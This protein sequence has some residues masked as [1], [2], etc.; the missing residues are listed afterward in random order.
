MFR[1]PSLLLC[2]SA[3]C[4]SS[5]APA[6]VL[7]PPSA[8][9]S[10][11]ETA[12]VIEAGSLTEG[13]NQARLAKL[14]GILA[15]LAG[16]S[17]ARGIIQGFRADLLLGLSRADEARL[18]ADESVR[19]LPGYS[20]PLFLA[21]QV[22]AYGDQ[23]E[24]AADY[25]IRASRIDPFLLQ[26]LDSYEVA[27][28][29]RRLQMKGEVERA[30]AFG[31]RLLDVSWKGDDLSTRS[32]MV[33]TLLE[34]R[35]ERGELARARGL[36]P[37][38]VDPAD[39]YRLLAVKRYRPIW[40]ELEAWAGSR[41]EKQW[42]VYLPELRE[43]WEASR[44]LGAGRSYLRG[45]AMANHNRA[46]VAE[47]LPVLSGPLNKDESA[48][49]LLMA[50]TVARALAELGRWDEID[51]MYSR[52][53]GIWPLGSDVM[54]LNL[55]GN[56]ARYLL[57]AGKAEQALPLIDA[58]IAEA[59]KRRAEVGMDAMAVM[60]QARACILHSLGRGDEGAKS[61]ALGRL[62]SPS[63]LSGV[64]SM[65]SCLERPEEARQAVLAAFASPQAEEEAVL[66]M[67][68]G[69]EQPVGSAFGQRLSAA[70]Q[71]LQADPVLLAAT[72]KHGRIL[73]F[74]AGSAA[75]DEVVRSAP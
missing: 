39:M 65:F 22:H 68:P 43:R 63:V 14:D 59:E 50:S 54:A 72:R 40:P 57:Y 51:A 66:L 55:T 23:P 35:V 4:L 12:A 16:P 69:E 10:A 38:L 3:A 42:A 60:H 74:S 62:G 56:R 2:L 13:S 25:L 8:L 29:L 30:A 24:L 17:K 21:G 27:N 52:L 18:A 41:L 33:R 73:P 15:R 32:G 45:L 11:E 19:L 5:P 46:I 7:P 36:V 1:S 28:L 6:E 9:G 26:A 61:V 70:R 47:F 71:A 20:G 49:L 37:E 48:E 53:S 75:P 34:R 67:Q 31:E 44:D 64:V 58:S